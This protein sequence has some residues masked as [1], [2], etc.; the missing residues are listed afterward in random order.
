M[1]TVQLNEVTCTLEEAETTF[2]ADE[3][4]RRERDGV[5]DNE[6][7]VAIDAG[8]NPSR[9]LARACA[10]FYLLSYLRRLHYIAA[11]GRALDEL[12]GDL[13]PEFAR[14]LDLACGGELR[15]A[16]SWPME[17]P[18]CPMLGRGSCRSLAWR[19]WL[20][21]EDPVYRARYAAEA[22]E[23]A[24][25]PSR[26]YGGEP[27]AE[28]ALVLELHLTGKMSP[29]VFVDRVWNLQHHGGICLNKV[30]DTEGLGP[31]LEAHGQDDH[32]T[33]LSQAS[34]NTRALWHQAFEKKSVR[35]ACESIVMWTEINDLVKTAS[36]TLA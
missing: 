27:W 11:A 30:Y 14:Y 18:A 25:W 12:A 9:D 1:S 32:D 29:E 36:T 15:H 16:S 19:D 20:S 2:T 4:T 23:Q 31:V 13:A 35:D 17:L 3:S 24:A 22:F 7:R 28:I 26:N 10:D 5:T 8:L 21:W 6:T 33:L 34:D